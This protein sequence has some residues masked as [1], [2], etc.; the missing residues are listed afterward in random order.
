MSGITLPMWLDILVCVCLLLGAFS[1]LV[2]A[3]ALLR[4]P[5]SVERLHGPTLIGSVGGGFIILAM[6]LLATYTDSALRTAPLLV[7]GLLLFTT[8]LVGQALTRALRI[9][10][11]PR[12]AD[13]LQTPAAAHSSI[14][15]DSS[16]QTK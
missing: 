9:E 7:M 11:R 10:V 8:P 2:G 1:A 13:T 5:T 12:S 14:T 15:P 3:W 6:V 4:L 16:T